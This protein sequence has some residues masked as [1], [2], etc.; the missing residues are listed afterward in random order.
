[1]RR[2]HEAYKLFKAW[3]NYKTGIAKEFDEHMLHSDFFPNPGRAAKQGEVRIDASTYLIAITTDKINKEIFDAVQYYLMDLV[4]MNSDAGWI[5]FHGD[6]EK[7]YMY[8]NFLSVEKY[9]D[10][11][12]LT[13]HDFSD[14]L[15]ENV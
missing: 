6:I 11:T 12:D 7:Y 4:P 14:I 9:T 13:E 3:F 1:M 8:D 5:A 10:Y 2:M 15:G